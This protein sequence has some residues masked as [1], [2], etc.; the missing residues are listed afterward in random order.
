MDADRDYDYTGI[1]D[2][3]PQPQRPMG[4]PVPAQ[5]SKKF[6]QIIEDAQ[7]ANLDAKSFADWVANYME[8]YAALFAHPSF[9]ASEGSKTGGPQC[10]FCGAIWP[11][12]G[13]SHMSAWTPVN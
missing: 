6:Q 12:C 10:S 4:K 5:A 11:L 13:H 9:D 7:R 2:F 1:F 3:D 8:G